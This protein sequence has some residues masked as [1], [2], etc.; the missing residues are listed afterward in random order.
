MGSQVFPLP[1]TSSS[2]SSFILNQAARP[3]KTMDRRHLYFILYFSDKITSIE[4][5]NDRICA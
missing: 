1:C 5:A 2:S 4:K 3:I